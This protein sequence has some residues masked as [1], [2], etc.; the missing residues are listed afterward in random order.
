MTPEAKPV[1]ISQRLR[2]RP[3]TSDDAADLCALDADA[4]VRRYVHQPE[5][6]KLASVRDELIPRWRRVDAETPAVGYWV[7]E[8]A[9]DGSF[10]GWFH[11][12]PPR[13]GAPLREDDLVLGYRLRRAAWGRGMATEG[14]RLLTAYAF[15][16][17]NAPRVAAIALEA[18]VASVRVMEKL[19]MTLVARWDYEPGTPAVA[20]A[21]TAAEWRRL[22]S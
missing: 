13:P 2:L 21:I 4:E 1:L 16:R 17:L 10:M 12:R 14:G 11:L 8:A 19:G 3:V 22:T 9:G 5:A 15:E 6:P 18:N 20:Y 7:A